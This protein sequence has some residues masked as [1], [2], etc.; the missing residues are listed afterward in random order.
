MLLLQKSGVQLP[1]HKWQHITFCNSTNRIKHLLLLPK[2]IRY[3]HDADIHAGKVPMYIKQKLAQK[4]KQKLK[5]E[6]LF[7][8]EIFLLF[9]C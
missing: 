4:L 5:T 8:M 3:I 7:S 1:A 6:N 2:A 9:Y